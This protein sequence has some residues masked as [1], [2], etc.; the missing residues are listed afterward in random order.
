MH[1]MPAQL[2]IRT[3]ADVEP[4]T[5]YS[6]VS[7]FQYLYRRLKPM[8]IEIRVD[9]QLPD[10]AVVV[11]ESLFEDLGRARELDWL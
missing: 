6:S 3:R 10:E 11:D 1:G 4:N 2:E 8:G 9:S 5:V 7:L